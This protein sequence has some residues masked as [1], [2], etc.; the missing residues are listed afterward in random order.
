MGMGSKWGGRL[1]PW[2]VPLCG[3]DHHYEFDMSSHAA[4]AAGLEGVIDKRDFNAAVRDIV[5]RMCL[6]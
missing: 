2:R 3:A 1:K 5:N 6:V 4:V